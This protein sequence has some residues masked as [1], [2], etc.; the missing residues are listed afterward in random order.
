MMSYWNLQEA[1]WQGKS[2]QGD[3]VVER[4]FTFG[5]AASDT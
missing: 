4:D 2:S 3:V 1:F 5:F